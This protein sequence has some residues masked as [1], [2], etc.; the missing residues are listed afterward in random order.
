VSPTRGEICGPAPRGVLLLPR[1][2]FKAALIVDPTRE[3]EPEIIH[4]GDEFV[5]WLCYANAGM[6]TSG[7]LYL[8][9]YALR[10]LPPGNA[11]ILEIGSFC[12]LS[13]N[14]LTYYKLKHGV[15]NRLIT[16]DK[17]QILRY[18]FAAL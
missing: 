8:F 2:L 1:A 14:L 10:R 15:K 3:S 12:G 5:T 18:T 17:G 4:I 7:N 16:C 9:D 11:P 13:T 6:L